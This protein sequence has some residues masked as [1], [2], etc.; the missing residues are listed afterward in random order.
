VNKVETE[1]T[2]VAEM[3]AVM[4]AETKIKEGQRSLLLL[5]QFCMN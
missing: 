2:A 1:M 4:M 5:F 3:A